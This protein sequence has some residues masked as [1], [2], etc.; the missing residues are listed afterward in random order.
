MVLQLAIQQRFAAW[1]DRRIPRSGEITLNQRRIFIF[2]SRAG[3]VFLLLVLG[4]L[5]GG[6]NYENNM[7]FSFAFLLLG[8]FLITILHTYSNLSGLTLRS[9]AARPTFAGDFADFELVLSRSGLRRYEGIRF[10]WA[11]ADPVTADLVKGTQKR[12][13]IFVP[14]PNRGVLKLGRLLVETYYPL[15]LIR[16]WTWLDFDAKCLVY[17]RPEISRAELQ[18]V[19][20]ANDEGSYT[21]QHGSDDFA[22]FKDYVPGDSLKQVAWRNVAK[23]LPIM[24]KHYQSQADH[25]IWIDWEQ[26][27]GEDTETRL[28]RMCYLVLFAEQQAM[29]YGMR[30]P[31]LSF[32]PA[33]GTLHKLQTLQALALYGQ[34]R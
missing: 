2:P 19:A 25:Q 1:L 28:S 27:D 34:K 7:L 15:G 5:L 32:P 3:L 17:P 26:F 20:E 10:A 16:A 33:I 21:Q 18:S 13:S 23:G 31:G 8:V 24:T 11:D 30:L 22:G 9:T 4:L 14:A 6:I 29:E 12:I